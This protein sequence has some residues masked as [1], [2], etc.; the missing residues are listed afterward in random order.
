VPADQAFGDISLEEGGDLPVQRVPG[1]PE[2][3]DWQ[4]A[5]I[6][7]AF[8]QKNLQQLKNAY[9]QAEQLEGLMFGASRAAVHHLLERDIGAGTGAQKILNLIP[10]GFIQAVQFDFA[11]EKLFYK[12]IEAVLPTRGFGFF[13]VGRDAGAGLRFL[14]FLLVKML[15]VVASVATLVP[16]RSLILRSDAAQGRDVGR[17]FR[18]LAIASILAWAGAVTA[19]RLLAYLVV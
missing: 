12:D 15:L 1:G 17:N 18:L 16:V 14:L 10:T 7:P 3:I 2:G 11:F 19:G 6:R 8:H 4:Q 9:L 5:E 13:L